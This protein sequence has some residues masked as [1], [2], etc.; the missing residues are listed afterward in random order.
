MVPSK[1]VTTRWKSPV[2]NEPPDTLLGTLIG[3]V[4]CWWRGYHTPP[5]TYGWK[6]L[7]GGFPVWCGVCGREI[8]LSA[9]DNV[10]SPEEGR[11]MLVSVLHRETKDGKSI[12][13]G[14]YSTKKKAKLAATGLMDHINKMSAKPG[15][16]S[17]EEREHEIRYS[18]H[19]ETIVIDF[20][21]VDK[22]LIDG[23]YKMI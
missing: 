14:I 9:G 2:R 13:S 21:S 18:R 12:L 11:E 20:W 8:R 22:A 6:F 15:K 7:V 1:P 4:K 5:G 3:T 16:W 10:Q 17:V 19:G 23:Q